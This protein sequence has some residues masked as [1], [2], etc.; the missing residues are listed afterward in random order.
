MNTDLLQ[1]LRFIHIVAAVFWV[2]AAV[3]MGF[4]VFPVL[5][6]GDLGTTRL[7]RQIMMGR[8]LAIILPVVTLLVVISGG[9]LYWIDF[10]NMSM[11]V[12]TPRALDYTL[13]AF[14]G[15]VALIVGFSINMPTGIKLTAVMDSIGTASPTIEQSNEI[16]RLS[17][18]LLIATRCIAILTLGS[19]ALMAL[20]RY[21]R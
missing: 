17:R 11:S 4:F 21:A 8:K 13:G 20:A 1:L 10:P 18:K 3:T 15:I 9:Y 14:L 7:T 2:G 19:A 12:F 5:L 16:A 6:T